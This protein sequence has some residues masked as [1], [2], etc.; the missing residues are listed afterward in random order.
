MSYATQIIGV[1]FMSA[2]EIFLLVESALQIKYMINI[3]L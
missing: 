2:Q 3:T 1:N